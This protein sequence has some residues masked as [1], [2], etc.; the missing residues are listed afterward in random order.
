MDQIRDAME[1]YLN[2]HA[3]PPWCG[4]PGYPGGRDISSFNGQPAYVDSS[5]DGIFVNFLVTAGLLPT[6]P[7]DPFNTFPY[8]Y[9]YAN[10]EF[11][12]GSGKY[13]T[14]FLGTNLENGD[15]PALL[16]SFQTGIPGTQDM[17]IIAVPQ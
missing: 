15:N 6:T 12:N 3:L 9:A 5:L 17:Y 1:M 2:S 11:P 4:S 14:Y 8:F 16:S 10:G 7:L 13:F